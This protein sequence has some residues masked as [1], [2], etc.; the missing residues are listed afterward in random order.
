MLNEAASLQAK[1]RLIFRVMTQQRDFSVTPAVLSLQ[2]SSL[3]RL[4]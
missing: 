2:Y 1:G 3:P 4:C